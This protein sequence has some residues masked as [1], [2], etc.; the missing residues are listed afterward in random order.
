MTT[1]PSNDK[2]GKTVQQLLDAGAAYLCRHGIATDE[3]Q[4][5]AEILFCDVLRLRGATLALHLRDIPSEETLEPLRDG[6]KRLAAGEPIQ[7]LIGKWPFHEIELKTD[8]R[9]LIPRPETEILVERILAHPLWSRAETI[10]D[11][12]TGT[13]AIILSLAA[14]AKR[15]KDD[16]KKFIAIDLSPD[17]LALAQENCEALGLT[18]RVS[19]QLSN[20]ASALPPNS[21]DI[22]VSN[23]PYIATDVVNHLPKLILDHEPRMALDG[24]P[25]GLDILRQ[26]VL[27]ATQ[28]LHSGGRIFLEMGDEQGLAMRKILDCAGY[29]DVVIAKDYAGHDRFAEG[30]LP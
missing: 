13:G 14:A 25:D 20:G 12:G 24:G 28:V 6:L 9:A 4:T 18:D 2:N 8:P 17:A 16:R 15:A 23:P 5:Q 22:L 11:I 29:T 3:A 30:T 21:C 19:F 26:I 1:C 7:Y 27:D 10:V